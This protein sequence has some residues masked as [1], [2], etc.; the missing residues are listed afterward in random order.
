M[1]QLCASRSWSVHLLGYALCLIITV[2]PSF[3]LNPIS[4]YFPEW[5][6]LSCVWKCVCRAQR[7]PWGWDQESEQSMC[8]WCQWLEWTWLWLLVKA[9]PDE[10]EGRLGVGRGHVPLRVQPQETTGGGNWRALECRP[11]AGDLGVHQHLHLWVCVCK[12]VSAG[13]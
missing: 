4:S 2:C 6:S 7:E 11:S 12:G 1:S 9:L 10:T 8:P 3:S 13:R 5:E